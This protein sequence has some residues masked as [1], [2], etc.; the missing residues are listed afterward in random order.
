MVTETVPKDILDKLDTGIKL[1]DVA[2]GQTVDLKVSLDGE[3][4]NVLSDLAQ[5][6]T[7]IFKSRQEGTSQTITLHTVPSGKLFFIISAGC[8]LAGN[9]VASEEV[10]LHITPNGAAS[11]RNIIVAARAA[12][13]A[14]S[15]VVGVS[16]PGG[17]KLTADQAIIF[18]SLG[19]NHTFTAWFIGYETNA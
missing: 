13:D 3:V 11:T 12:G 9:T 15:L 16:F 10:N 6:G 8:N 4:I 14:P 18:K 5:S 1:G 2:S 19:S 17:F 7:R